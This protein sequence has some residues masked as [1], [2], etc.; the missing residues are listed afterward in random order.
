MDETSRKGLEEALQ[1]RL[2]AELHL[3][4]VQELTIAA[5]TDAY[6][7]PKVF[8]DGIQKKREELDKQYD[9]LREIAGLKGGNSDGS[10]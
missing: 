4:T 7:K 1:I 10:T 8:L 6:I 3:W 9:K 5:Q 2:A